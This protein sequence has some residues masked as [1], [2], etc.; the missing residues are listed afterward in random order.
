[1][2]I[3]KIDTQPKLIEWARTTLTVC[4]ESEQPQSCQRSMT[5]ISV[6]LHDVGEEVEADE[7]NKGFHRYG[8]L[9]DWTTERIV[10]GGWDACFIRK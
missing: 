8:V 6:P 5:K 1:M 2:R 10:D 3:L 9:I 4:S 7:V